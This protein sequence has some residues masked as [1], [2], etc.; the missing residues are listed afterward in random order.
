MSGGIWGF[1]KK[2]IDGHRIVST[3]DLTLFK[4]LRREKKVE[5][6]LIMRLVWDGWRYHGS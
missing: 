6:L 5:F 3:G 2:F 1:M 4:L